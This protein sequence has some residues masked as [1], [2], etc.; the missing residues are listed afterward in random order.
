MISLGTTSNFKVLL[1]S[2]ISTPAS[3]NSF[4]SSVSTFFLPNS[5]LLNKVEDRELGLVR[6]SETVDSD[7][8]PPP[9][10][11]FN[12]DRLFG[13]DGAVPVEVD[14]ERVV[15]LGSEAILVMDA[16]P[17]DKELYVPGLDDAAAVA[18]AI[19]S[20]MISKSDMGVEGIVELFSFEEE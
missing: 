1:I 20:A 19:I 14:E 10:K 5:E 2:F 17:E 3:L 15:K 12:V 13:V 18:L 6:F 11:L 16:L 8:D 9:N 4:S 7:L